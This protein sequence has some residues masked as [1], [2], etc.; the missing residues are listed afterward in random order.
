M[1]KTKFF[2]ISAFPLTGPAVYHALVTKYIIMIAWSAG[3]AVGG[4]PTVSEVTGYVYG[5]ALPLGLLVTSAMA[6]VGVVRSRHTG[7]TRLEYVGTLL[8][9]AGLVG[10]SV[11]IVLRAIVELD[12]DDLPGALLP[13]LVAVF[14][15][16]RLR[17]ILKK[18]HGGPPAT[19]PLGVSHA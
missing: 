7:R 10:Y 4:I 17:N 12:W 9:I 11:A 19:P 16:Y 13:I 15:Y 3:S 14:P 2:E 18:P 1:S 8:L 6:L 5:V